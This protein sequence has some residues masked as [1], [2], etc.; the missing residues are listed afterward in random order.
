M[1]RGRRVR[2]TTERARACRQAR[3]GWAARWATRGAPP[4]ACTA[5]GAEAP[6]AAQV[7]AA[8]GRTV[9][10]AAGP[11]RRAVRDLRAA[12]AAQPQAQ[13]RRGVALRR[14]PA[15]QPPR[16]PRRL[17]RWLPRRA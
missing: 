16:R 1:V 11:G 6:A 2:C 7:P 15:V 14:V 13:A 3:R 12:A 8:E 17:A 4:A 10:E 5:T 9:R